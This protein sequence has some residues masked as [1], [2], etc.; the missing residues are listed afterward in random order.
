MTK[1]ASTASVK[2]S[3]A[4][5]VFAKLPASRV[6]HAGL[7]PMLLVRLRKHAE[8]GLVYAAA[9]KHQSSSLSYFYRPA[10]LLTAAL[11][12]S[13]AAGHPDAAASPSNVEPS[14]PPQ[15]PSR[16]GI[17]VP[18]ALGPAVLRNRIKRRVRVLAR[19]QIH[20]LPEG[21]DVVLHPRPKVATMPHQEL[22]QELA[23]VFHEIARRIAAG[24]PNTPLPRQPRRADAR[25]KTQHSAGG[26]NQNQSQN[27]GQTTVQKQAQLPARHTTQKAGQS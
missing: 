25:Q 12:T 23:K 8:Y 22:Q 1:A 10:Q 6:A 26:R 20:L 16:F 15:L 7:A 24:A 11:Q 19:Q 2:T 4:A 21:T 27:Q 5:G 14:V 17:T 3:A 9:R 18:R 13:G